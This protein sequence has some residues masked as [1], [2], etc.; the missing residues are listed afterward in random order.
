MELE[1]KESSENGFTQNKSMPNLD[2][3]KQVKIIYKIEAPVKKEYR[4]ITEEDKAIFDSLG[5]AYS[6][7]EKLDKFIF[8]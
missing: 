2:I 7:I 3:L 1:K 5:I 6:W 4:Q 8:T